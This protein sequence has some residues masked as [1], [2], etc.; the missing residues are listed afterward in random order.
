MLPPGQRFTVDVTISPDDSKQW[1]YES[2]TMI[3]GV[4]GIKSKFSGNHVKIWHECWTNLGRN[5]D[6]AMKNCYLNLKQF[7]FKDNK[8]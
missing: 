6:K 7:S 4:R 8:I 1:C 2:F 3:L 5:V